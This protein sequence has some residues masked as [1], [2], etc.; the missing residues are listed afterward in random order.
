MT[1]A[2]PLP[3]N[4][5]VLTLPADARFTGRLDY[6]GEVWID[7][8]L[9]GVIVCRALVIRPT[10]HVLG[11]VVAEH[12]TVLGSAEAAIYADRLLLK[13][14]CSV[15]GE[16]HHAQLVIEDEAFFEGKSRRD[17]DPRSTARKLLENGG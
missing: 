5:A 14:G 11:Q 15:V 6:P 10:A 1:S 16:A 9:D 2:P 3:D 7:G 4:D 17:P 8:R 12:V 13:R